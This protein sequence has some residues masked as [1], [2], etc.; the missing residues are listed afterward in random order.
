MNT[1]T[2]AVGLSGG[3]DSAVAAF[4]LKEQ[5]Y[6]VI[7]I[8]MKIWD[9]S[10]E[11]REDARHAC[12]GPGEEED[13]E[14]ARQVCACLDIPYH[15]FDLSGQYRNT[16]IDYF[17]AEYRAGR[18]PNPCVKCNDRMKFGFLL[19]AAREAGH[20]FD[21][22]A[23]GHYA[24]IG[25]TDAGACVLM[26]GVDPLKDQSYF[27]SGLKREILPGL[28]FP[29]G[30]LCKDEVRSI[31][32][33]AALP[34]A[35][36]PESQDFIA[37]GDYAPLFC[38]NDIRPGAITDTDGNVLGEHAGIINYTIGQRRGLGIG[39]SPE[40]RYV[41]AIDAGANRV[42]VGGKDDLLA[43]GLVARGINLL[44]GDALPSS[45]RVT[46]KIR[47]NHPGVPASVEP[48]G[49]DSLR[50]LF[51]TPQ[52]SVTPGQSVVLYDGDVVLCGG[53]IESAVK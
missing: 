39:G 21:Y 37:G 42:V 7:G 12:F 20:G 1:R 27:L 13:V 40:P 10:F 50:V 49:E 28:L 34:V 2:V 47:Q 6:R 45:E 33:R 44:A 24:R 38:C 53:I 4:L 35:E 46:A 22:F 41:V 31:A 15:V 29:L 32:R 52:A 23:T 30:E 14:H 51:E 26:R 11:I 48:A 43:R 36:L 9:N 19:E 3:V 17:T 25:R 16:V 8:T 5:G 18:T